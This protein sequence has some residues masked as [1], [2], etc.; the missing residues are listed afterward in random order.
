M[1]A[2]QITRRMA[3]GA[4]A[5]MLAA[6]RK[7][8]EPYFGRTVP[9]RRQRLRYVLGAGFE[10]FVIPALFE[11]LTGYHPKT[12]WPMAALATHVEVAPHPSQLTF[13][14]RG[15][16]QPR[17]QA[18]PN[19]NTLHEEYRA[20]KLKQDFSRG[21]PAPPDTIPA[22]W[23]DGRPVTAHDFVYSWRRLVD[24]ETAAPLAFLLN[25]VHNAQA[26]QSGQLPPDRLGVKALDDFTLI[27]EVQGL[28]SLFLEM[29]P[30]PTLAAV[31]RWAVEA[32]KQRGR[33]SSWTEPEHIVTNGG[34]LLRQ[35]RPYEK[36]VV[37]RNPGYY[38]ASLV[39]LEEIE[40]VHSADGVTTANLY[41]ADAVD[42]MPGERL[43]ALL[44]PLL[45]G[46]R[47]FHI[48]P[49]WFVIFYCFNVH[50]PPFDRVLLRYALNMATDKAAI[51]RCFGA[52][53]IA[54]RNIV[55]PIAGYSAPQ[56][57][58]V[59]IDGVT[60]DVLAYDPEAARSLLSKAG[61]PNGIGPDGRP[62]RFEALF[63]TL[64]HSRPIVEMLHQQ[65]RLHLNVELKLVLQEF[66]VW[67]QNMLAT[68]YSGVAEGGGW[69]DYLDPKGLFD[70]FANGSPASGTGY[71]DP[72]FDGMLEEANAVV[73]PFTRMQ[74]LADCER[75]L[76]KSMPVV[77]IFHNVWLYLQKPFVCGMEANVLDKHPFKYAWID[78]S[79]RPR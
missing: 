70:W 6:C 38:E 27:V 67:L 49:A 13:Y 61:Y 5:T 8:T 20:G 52:G 56:S 4:S 50:K 73:D 1:K 78:T 74:N 68:Q 60:Y 36:I 51:A 30:V 29:L 35:R 37:V 22:F 76:L 48:T 25:A 14:L 65:W 44:Q 41:R 39:A 75:H 10:S 12:L 3:L 17:G 47:D 18:L 19:T 71:A 24:P 9:P 63:P 7:A 53:R 66:K 2:D 69:P 77:P 58:P 54:A 11:G 55:P 16:P 46:H 32:A 40:F 64:P 15:H 31:P 43:S 42:A 26:I 62:F 34:F 72:V 23:S 79:W 45:E 59:T 33:E 21:C 57:L 28:A